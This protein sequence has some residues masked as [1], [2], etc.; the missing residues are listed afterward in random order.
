MDHDEF[1]FGIGEAGHGRRSGRCGLR[2]HRRGQGAEH[3][4]D[5]CDCNFF[6][7]RFPI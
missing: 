3:Q 7:W 1:W 2:Q 5:D 6:H 4:Q